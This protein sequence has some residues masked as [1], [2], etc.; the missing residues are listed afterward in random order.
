[1]NDYQTIL[2]TGSNGQLGMCLQQVAQHYPNYKF[3][4][5]DSTTLD[6]TNQEKVNQFFSKN[7]IDYCINCAAYTAVDKAEQ[8]EA[9]AM[10]VNCYGVKNLAEACKNFQ[11]KLFH[12]ST[13]YVFDGNGAIPYKEDDDTSPVNKYGQTKL[14]GEHAAFTNTQTIVLR[15]SWVYAPFGKNFVKTMQR[16]MAEKPEI[17]VVADQYGS[18]TYAMD[19]A[20]AIMKIIQANSFQSGIYHYSNQGVINWYEFALAIKKWSNSSCE[21]KAIETVDYPTPAKRPAYSALDKSKFI[22]TFGFSIPNWEES[23]ACYFN[24]KFY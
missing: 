12:I 24:Y 8:E 4:F 7:T 18:P 20:D 14:A 1:M 5:T 2:V 6:I 16:L 22:N 17:S 13:D 21:I 15:I 3:I 23:L 10:L 11:V 19:L 9:Q